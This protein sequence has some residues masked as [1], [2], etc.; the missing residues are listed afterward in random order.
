MVH[1][2][3]IGVCGYRPFYYGGSG[4]QRTTDHSN[5]PLPFNNQANFSC[6]EILGKVRR[7]EPLHF[8]Y[9]GTHMHTG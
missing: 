8:L 3:H 6:V 1:K 2:E 4:V 5:R 9:E 7:G